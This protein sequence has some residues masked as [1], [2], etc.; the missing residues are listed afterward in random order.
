MIQNQ[1][2]FNQYNTKI[3]IFPY[4]YIITVL[5]IVVRVCHTILTAAQWI[6]GWKTKGGDKAEAITSNPES[7]KPT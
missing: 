4:Q 5:L 3:I 1:Q 2:N 7:L 6:S